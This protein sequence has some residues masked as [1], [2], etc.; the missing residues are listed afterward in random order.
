MSVLVV[1]LFERVKIADKETE[2]ILLRNVLEHID[3]IFLRSAAVVQPRQGVRINARLLDV[4]KEEEYDRENGYGYDRYPVELGVE[5]HPYDKEND[6]SDD[7][8]R[9]APRAVRADLE[10][11]IDGYGGDDDKVDERADRKRDVRGAVDYMSFRSDGEYHSVTERDEKHDE[12]GGK[13]HKAED[14]RPLA[15]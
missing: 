1:D 6:R 3:E 4:D 12:R 7:G 15:P 13:R 8:K 9:V 11:F 5:E 2:R 10:R 14:I